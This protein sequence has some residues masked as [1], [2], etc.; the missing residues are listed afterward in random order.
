MGII[1]NIRVDCIVNDMID[2]AGTL[3]ASVVKRKEAGAGDIYV[4]YPRRCLWMQSSALTTLLSR[5]AWLPT[6]FLCAAA[7]QEGSKIKTI[8]IANESLPRQFTLAALSP[9]SSVATSTCNPAGQ[10]RIRGSQGDFNPYLLRVDTGQLMRN[11][12]RWTGFSPGGRYEL[13]RVRDEQVR[14]MRA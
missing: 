12:G 13:G 10:R 11:A 4:R 1:G 6:Q 7:N 5:G 8:T 3:C 9:T 2:T 14:L